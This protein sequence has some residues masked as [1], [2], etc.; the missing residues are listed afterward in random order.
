MDTENKTDLNEPPKQK[1]SRKAYMKEY[2]LKKRHQLV[3]GKFLKQKPKKN[4]VC[5]LS[6]THGEYVVSFN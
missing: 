2:Y 5:P 3:E 1:K 6:I 4:K